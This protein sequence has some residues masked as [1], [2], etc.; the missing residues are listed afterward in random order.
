L[1][2]VS[3]C[4]S[5]GGS[6]DTGAGGASI[7]IFVTGTFSSPTLS[8]P[9][10][11]SG[12]Q[13]AADTINAAG[14]VDGHKIDIVSCNDQFTPSGAQSCAQK[15]VAAK[16]TAVTGQ[17]LFAAGD[18]NALKP[19][20]IPL[21]DGAPGN[22]ALATAPT[23][24][25][26]NGGGTAEYQGIGWELA[27]SGFKKVVIIQGT[28]PA[29]QNQTPYIESGVKLEGGETIRVIS[30]QEGTPDFGPYVQTALS[31]GQTQAIVFE[32]VP[33]DLPTLVSAAKQANFKGAIGTSM[34]EI[35]P[36]TLKQLGASA[37]DLWLTSSFFLP[38]SPQA[39]AFATAMKRYAPKAALDTPS[40]ATYSAVTAIAAGLKGSA[41][42]G[43]SD[44]DK[45]L[46]SKTGLNIGTFAPPT[47]A[48]RRLVGVARSVARGPSILLLDEPAA[49][50]D[51]HEVAEIGTLVRSLA[52]DRGMGVLLV[53]HQLEM[54][55]STCDRLIVLDAGAILA[56]G[57]HDEVMRNTYVRT[58]YLGA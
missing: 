32:G 52:A 12:A 47:F 24:F 48:Q 28:G 17:F 43:A 1:A 53:E 42:F 46:A 41:S 5:S 21:V 50:L 20:G 22:V 29:D 26:L 4:S 23:V 25:G 15:A 13:A 10:L 44:L 39:S 55:A 6:R 27:K 9:E 31:G 34:L 40:L 7:K 8:E 49:G 35:Q 51:A 56:A 19:A 57:T 3:G 16:V 2:L 11:L 37:D 14:G 58:A 38:P 18:L 45:A 54:V 33:N 30:A 36:A